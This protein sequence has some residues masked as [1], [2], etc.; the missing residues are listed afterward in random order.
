MNR[1]V[2]ISIIKASRDDL[3]EILALQK[4]AYQC[5]A[6]LYDDWTIPPLTQTIFEMEAEFGIYVFLKTVCS[7]PDCWI[8]ERITQFRY[9]LDW[10]TNS[11]PRLPKKGHRYRTHEEHRKGFYRGGTVRVIYGDQKHR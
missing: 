9:M 11:S 5:E 2:D 7:R 4:I 6:M 3:S 10:Q 1:I 8:C